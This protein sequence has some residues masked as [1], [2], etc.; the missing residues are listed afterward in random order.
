RAVVEAEVRAIVLQ[1]AVPDRGVRRG[2]ERHVVL[3]V[4]QIALD[5]VDELTALGDVERAPL[6]Q[7]EIGESGIVDVALVL[8]L[9]GVVLP[10]E[11][12]VGIQERRLR[13]IRHGL[14]LPDQA[15]RCERAVLLLVQARV[16]ADVLEVLEHERGGVDEDRGA[17]GREAHRS[18][19]ALR[20]TGRGG[21][22]L[23]LGGRGS[24]VA[25]GGS[26]WYQRAPSPSCAIGIDHSLSAAGTAGFGVPPPSATASR[27]PW[28]SMASDMARRTRTSLKG[29]RSV[30][31]EMCVIT[32]L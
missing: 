2:A 13:P 3:L 26:Y 6:P 5:L 7:Q 16:D 4:G 18:R 15:R 20:M 11:E 14:E 23:G 9:A 1:R 27:I 8:G 31:I 30:R 28:R 24:R 10:I 29:A 25:A 19:E 17:V 32:L 22:T 12:V 21:E